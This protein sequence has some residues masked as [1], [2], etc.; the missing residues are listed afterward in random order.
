[1]QKT[2]FPV[3]IL[4]HDDASTDDTPKILKEYEKKHP[5]VFKIIY[6]KEN[7]YSQGIRNMITRYLLPEAKG[8]YLALCEGDDYWTDPNKLQLQVDFLEKNPK[9]SLCF[10]PVKVIYDAKE[11]ADAVE[12]DVDEEKIFTVRELLE[13]NFIHTN[14]VM[15]RKQTYDN[16]PTN[17]LPG[18]WYLHLYH[19]Q[20]GEIGFINKVMSVYRRHAGGV[21]WDSHNDID[22]ILLKHGVAWLG[23][24]V[25]VLKIYQKHPE[26]IELIEGSIIT[27]FNRIIEVGQQHKVNL[28]EQALAAHPDAGVI[29]IKDLLKQAENLQKHSNEQAKIIQH[30]VDKAEQLEAEKNLLKGKK[31]IRLES[32]IRKHLKRK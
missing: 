13:R 32:S 5:N 6:R 4:I 21:W 20:F 1:M 2:D 30:Y 11:K 15:Y 31:L 17:I 19:A 28:L 3:E 10:H 9:H 8:K 12:P 7:L 14:S 26:H 27:M 22:K 16:M 24:H 25:E 23:M 29:Y 18:D